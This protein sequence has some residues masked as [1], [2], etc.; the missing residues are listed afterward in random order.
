LPNGFGKRLS[1]TIEAL[2]HNE[3]A[4]MRETRFGLYNPAGATFI[5]KL[6]CEFLIFA[7]KLCEIENSDIRTH[8]RDV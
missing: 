7:L 2:E 3:I 1:Y 4:A 6:C 5:S 8:R